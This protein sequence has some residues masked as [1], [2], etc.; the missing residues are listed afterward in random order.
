MSLVIDWEAMFVA[1][2]AARK[3][4]HA[5]YSKFFVGAAL[6]CE[7]GTIIAGCNVENASYGL[8]VCAERN[9]IARM[10]YE[11]KKLIAVAI[12]VDSQKPTPP[13]GMCRQVMA[14]FAP[15]SM[16]VRSRNLEG[17]EE[18]YTLGGLLPHA[19]TAEFL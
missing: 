11:G 8:T 3:R 18:R 9:A 19:F 16:E 12:V 17:S 4:A 2:E 7:D 6:G 10:V 14:E 15:A 5:R 13:C 1:A